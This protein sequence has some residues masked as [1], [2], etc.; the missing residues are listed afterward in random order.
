M[1]FTLAAA[2]TAVLAASGAS[3]YTINVVNNC[4]YAIWPAA[5]QHN[6]AGASDFPTLAAQYTGAGP[7]QR[8]Q[9]FAIQAPAHW[10]GGR[11]WIRTGCNSDGSSCAIGNCAGGRLCTDYNWTDKLT[12]AE[13]G[14]GDYGAF[15]GL[16]TSYDISRVQGFNVGMKLDGTGGSLNCPNS[17]C[18]RD[19]AY[20]ETND[21]QAVRNSGIN[22][23]FTLTICP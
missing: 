13:F 21:N 20:L 3:A 12:V 17:G 9:S 16:R 11:V 2:A 22:D 5:S 6:F 23:N 18:P 8:G 14:F 4:P 7:L 19:Q 10:L 1:K 15:G